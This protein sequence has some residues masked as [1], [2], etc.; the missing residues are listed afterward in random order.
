[1]KVRK[2]GAAI[3][4]GTI[5]FSAANTAFAD[6]NVKLSNL[7][8]Y[9]NVNGDFTISDTYYYSN[10][11][12]D[13][14]NHTVV[15]TLDSNMVDVDSN[16]IYIDEPIYTSNGKTM[17][18]L[19][20]VAETIKVFENNVNINWNSANKNVVISYDD[21]EIVFT[22]EKN[23]YT[24]NGKNIKMTD[25]I[26]EIKNGRIF[27]PVREIANV[28]NLSISWNPNSKKITISN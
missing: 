10:E 1:M 18:P 13:T 21:N 23:I 8:V 19:E 20:A 7:N 22:A 28:M 12:K 25:G 5:I 6:V 15:F 3:I 9:K 26:P 4:V 11:D 14:S 2:I 24:F 17:F 27:I 16:Y